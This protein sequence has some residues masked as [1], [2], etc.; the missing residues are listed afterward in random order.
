MARS[1]SL[2]PGF[3]TNE[4]LAELT[5]E[6]R[7][8]FAG[9]WTLAD[10]EGRLEDRPKRIGA[11]LFPYDVV[12]VDAILTALAGKEFIRRYVVDGVA[13]IDMPTFKAHQ[14]P[15]PRELQSEL[16]PYQAVTEKPRKAAAEPVKAR[17]GPSLPSCTSLPS[18]PSCVPEAAPRSGSVPAP[19][20][21]HTN[22]PRGA[23]IFSGK[24]HIA[25]AACGRVCVPAFLHRQFVQALGGSEDI[26]DDR[27]RDWYDGVFD[28]LNPDFPVESDAP[29]FWRPRFQSTFIKPGGVVA[30]YA[31]REECTHQPPCRDT[32]SHHRLTEAEASGDERMIAT[33]R[34]LAVAS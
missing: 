32:W 23:T 34:K 14:H 30:I 9:L 33:M 15:H 5:F 22:R 16:P 26:A 11:A 25:H 20:D 7:L 3:F 17:T 21:T 31:S 28:A 2:K 1:R 10:R 29:K 4:T 18:F 6:A 12:D 8:C 19:P 27:L 24:D 13:C